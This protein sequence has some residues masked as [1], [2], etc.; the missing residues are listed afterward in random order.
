[1]NDQIYNQEKLIHDVDDIFHVES[2]EKI[3][4]TQEYREIVM[5]DDDNYLDK[6]NN[7]K[8]NIVTIVFKI[9]FVRIVHLSK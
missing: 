6:V 8:K 3:A 9:I 5:I 7:V 2:K 4:L 1:M